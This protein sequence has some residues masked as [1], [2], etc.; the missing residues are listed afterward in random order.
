MPFPILLQTVLDLTSPGRV[1]PAEHT[2]LYAGVP[3]T[4]I[5]ADGAKF[6][7]GMVEPI[8]CNSKLLTSSNFLGTAGTAAGAEA[9]FE[10]CGPSTLGQAMG[11]SSQFLATLF[12]RRKADTAGSSLL[13]TID[14][15]ADQAIGGN[16][17][18]LLEQQ[19][20]TTRMAYGGDGGLLDCTGITPLLRRK[21]SRIVCC[22]SVQMVP[23][24]S[25][26]QSW[27]VSSNGVSA[28]FGMQPDGSDQLGRSGAAVKECMQAFPTSD[29]E[30]LW[31]SATS[32]F[33]AGR[34][35]THVQRSTV[36]RNDYLGVPGGWE[37]EVLWVINGA[38]SAWS[39]QLPEDTKAALTEARGSYNAPHLVKEAFEPTGLGPFPY[40]PTYCMRYT[41]ELVVMLSNQVAHAVLS[42]GDKIKEMAKS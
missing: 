18:M 28:L 10:L 41:P 27:L 2:P 37:V 34:P 16:E 9:E 15:R 8:G 39:D 5:G 3:S 4:I 7:G 35:I 21:V 14:Y 26:K 38:C 1:V 36:M 23:T 33:A 11:I 6:G 20:W 13:Y 42:V 12:A 19:D 22:P 32:A 40:V 24:E 25:N 17:L 30:A 31:A 29:F